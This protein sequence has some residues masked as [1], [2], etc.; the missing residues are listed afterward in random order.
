MYATIRLL[1]AITVLTAATPVSAQGLEAGNW[2]TISP[3]GGI[4]PEQDSL[5]PPEVVPLD[6]AAASSLSASQ[7]QSRQSSMAGQANNYSG[8]VPGL[9]NQD[10]AAPADLRKQ[11]FNQL[12]GGQSTLPP[13]AMNQIW[14]AGQTPMA[15]QAQAPAPMP[16]QH[17]DSLPPISGNFGQP[18][19]QMGGPN[20][21]MANNQQQTHEGYIAQSQTL[22]GGST[23]QAQ[24]VNT[25]RGGFSNMLNYGAAGAMGLGSSLMMHNPWLGAGIFGMTMTGFGVRNNSRF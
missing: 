12:Y 16:G 1:I 23:N 10:A 15:N 25:R 4:G 2:Q 13:N 18:A 22:T 8:N 3:S 5:L 24:Q 7:A 19:S 20:Y 11:A 9:V 6:P 21:Q 17:S 14:R